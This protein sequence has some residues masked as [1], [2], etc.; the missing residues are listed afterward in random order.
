MFLVWLAIAIL[1]GVCESVHDS[2]DAYKHPYQQ[3]D[4][5]KPKPWEQ[6]Y[7]DKCEAERRMGLRK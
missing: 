2:W 3:P 6:E 4:C 5:F 1:I 7:L